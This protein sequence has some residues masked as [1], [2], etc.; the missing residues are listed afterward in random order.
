MVDYVENYQ[1]WLQGEDRAKKTVETYAGE[2]RKF[3]TWWE[4][5]CGERFRPAAVEASHI[6]DY[7]T[8]LLTI[9][10]AA[11]ASINKALAAV[12]S[13][14]RWCQQEAH[15]VAEDPARKIKMRRVQD[16]SDQVRWLEV[17]E[18]ERLLGYFEVAKENLKNK[19]DEVIV[20]LGL[21]EG[22]RVE[23][24]VNIKTQHVDL[25]DGLVRVVNGKGGKYRVVDLHKACARAIREY[26]K[27]RDA[28]GHAY[29][30]SHYLL[31][32]ERGPRLT[33]RAV[34]LVLEALGKRLKIEGLTLHSLRHSFCKNLIDRGVPEKDVAR[35]AGHE[36]IATTRR[37]TKSSRKE[38]RAAINRL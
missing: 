27:Q 14:F 12:K 4:G 13:F 33:A 24:I 9:Q 1:K 37:Y 5:T 15:L 26:L 20:Y 25:R 22:L 19:R 8:Y 17:S 7:R 30:D 16:T 38:L 29:K 32:S 23:E 6:Q 31:L 35:L 18:Q 21:Y 10:G 3:I 11:P 2:I 34:Q 36:D 28:S